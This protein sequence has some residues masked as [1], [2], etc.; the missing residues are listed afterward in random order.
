[1]TRS[2]K[3][4]RLILCLCAVCFLS[5][6][7]RHLDPGII[8]YPTP[9]D[10]FARIDTDVPGVQI[11]YRQYPGEGGHVVLIHG[12]ASS[13]YTWEDMVPELQGKFKNS[14]KPCPR[15]WAVDMK[16][17]GWSDK[18][19]NAK[20]DPFTLADEVYK[21]MNTVGIDKATLVGNSLGG[22]IAWIMAL[23]HPEKVG[24]LVLVDAGGYSMDE[25]NYTA[26][27]HAPFLRTGAQL[28]FNRNVVKMVLQN[29]FYNKSKVT[30]SRVDAYYNRLRTIGAIDS[31]VLMI[32]TFD[33]QQ[34]QSYVKRIPDIKQETLIIWGEQDTWIP[35]KYGNQF[36]RDIKRS[37]L[38]VIPQCGHMPQEEKPGEV[39]G[40]LYRFLTKTPQLPAR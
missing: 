21:W 34:A 15:V 17:F 10:N 16:G 20:Y 11:H 35:L 25:S 22:S 39:A 14:G 38:M 36:K 30:G 27:A 8:L 32:K 37:T 4:A 9:H 40:E 31:Q 12:F 5:A 24:Q 6:C 7:V 19:L 2:R 29:A 28:L 18:P 33:P 3:I 13:A 26:F 1:M 23:E